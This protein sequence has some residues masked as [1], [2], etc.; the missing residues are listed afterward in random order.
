M[1]STV[2]PY[3]NIPSGDVRTRYGR[4]RYG[5]GWED[6]NAVPAPVLTAVARPANGGV[7]GVA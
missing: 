2:R 3:H 6:P 7:A 5:L 4:T 1:S